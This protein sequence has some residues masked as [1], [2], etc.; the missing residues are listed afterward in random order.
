MISPLA[1]MV[2]APAAVLA[3]MSGVSRRPTQLGVHEGRLAACPATPNCVSTQAD[4]PPHAIEPIRF[5]G[6]GAEAMRGL[7]S[8]I[9]RQPRARII[10]AGANYL[11]A[12]FTSLIFRFVD[13]VECVV[14]TNDQAIHFRSASRVGRSDLGANRRRMESIRAQFETHAISQGPVRPLNRR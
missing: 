4:G 2:V 11:H 14:D 7:R 13:D 12:E 8:I 1:L 3:V 10:T 9:E 5:T 6:S